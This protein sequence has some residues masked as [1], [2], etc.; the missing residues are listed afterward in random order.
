MS[1]KANGGVAF[2]AHVGG[3]AFGSLVARLLA[4]AGAGARTPAPASA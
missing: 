1:A 4:G 3:F 2:F